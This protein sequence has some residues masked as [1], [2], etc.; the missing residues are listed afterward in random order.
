MSIFRI[1]DFRFFS[2]QTVQCS[3]SFARAI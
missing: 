2:G 1:C 3:L